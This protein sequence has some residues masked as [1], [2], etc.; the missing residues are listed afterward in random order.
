MF[1][2]RVKYVLYFDI[3]TFWI[4][5]IIIIIIIIIKRSVSFIYEH[6]WFVQLIKIVENITCV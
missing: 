3:S 5:C 1:F 6:S 4:I 2:S